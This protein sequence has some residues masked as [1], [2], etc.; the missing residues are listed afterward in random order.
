MVGQRPGDG[1]PLL[2]P[3][4]Q[5]GGVLLRLAG[6][7]HQLQKLFCSGLPLPPAHARNLQ[8]QG[9]IVQDGALHEQIEFLEHHADFPPQ[10]QQLPPLNGGHVQPVDENLAAGGAL[11]QI[12]TSH[13]GG[14]ARAAHA[15]D[16]ENIPVLHR[17][18]DIFYGGK[19]A[20]V[21]AI[22]LGQAPYLYHIMPSP[23]LSKPARRPSGPALSIIPIF[24]AQRKPGTAFLAY[25]AYAAWSAE[26]RAE[27]AV[28]KAQCSM[29]QASQSMQQP[30]MGTGSMP[31]RT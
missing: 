19:G 24:Y 29:P 27:I 30:T 2:L 21:H 20:A 4:G 11:Q 7:A 22:G 3:A 25:R 16:A 28:K 12:D 9:H 23:L 1:N 5:L 8:G 10:L 18:V 17:E 13:Q 26:R 15:D 6:Q 31:R 14:F